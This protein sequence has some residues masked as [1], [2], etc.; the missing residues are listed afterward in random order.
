MIYRVLDR[1]EAGDA[2]G[3]PRFIR[4]RCTVWLARRQRRGAWVY[5][6]RRRVPPQ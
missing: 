6:Y 5:V 4:Q 2:R 1:Y 3:R